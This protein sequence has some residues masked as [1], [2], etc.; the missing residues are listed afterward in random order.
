M[1]E[2]Y[3]FP[4]HFQMT[5]SPSN[6]DIPIIPIANMGQ[7]QSLEKQRTIKPGSSSLHCFHKTGSLDADLALLRKKNIWIGE[8]LATQSDEED[9]LPAS[10]GNDQFLDHGAYEEKQFYCEA[11]CRSSFSDCRNGGFLTRCIQRND[12][13]VRGQF[14]T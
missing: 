5:R 1:V 12:R 8:G 2:I 3:T 6:C 10:L 13:I 7:D 4:A 9:A 11:C 14:S